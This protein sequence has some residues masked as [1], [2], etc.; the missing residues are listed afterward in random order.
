VASQDEQIARAKWGAE[1]SAAFDRAVAAFWARA[2]ELAEAEGG[3]ELGI[4]PRISR[5]A[6][7]EVRLDRDERF[8]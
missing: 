3:A 7:S 5:G 2:R 6:L 4:L 8:S 1:K